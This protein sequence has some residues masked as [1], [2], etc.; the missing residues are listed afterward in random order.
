MPIA[1]RNVLFF[2]EGATLAHVGRPFVLAET[3]D[4][5]EFNVV[6]ARPRSFSWLTAPATFAVLDL[7][8]QDSATFARRLDWGQPLYDYPTLKGYV[9]QDLELIAAVKPDVIVGDFRLSLAVSARKAKVPYITV[10]DAYWSPEYPLNPPLPVLG[11]TRF[12]P[13]RVADHA[14]RLVAPLA[15]RLHTIPME[16]LRRHFGLRPIG[17]DIRQCYT[18][19][20]YRL[21]ANIPAL[22]P[23]I[24]RS[25]HGEFIGPIAW[26]PPPSGEVEQFAGKQQIVYVT[27]GSS[28]D[29]RVLNVLLPLLEQ[30][31]HKAL[32]A[33]AGKPVQKKL[34][35]ASSKI[36]DYV[37]GAT[38]CKY[39]KLVV[40]NGGSPTTNQA[41]NEGVPV[42]G[43]ARNM[44]QF[45]NMQAIA[46]YGAGIKTRSDRASRTVLGESLRELL[47][48]ERYTRRAR[49]LTNNADWDT[50]DSILR[51]ILNRP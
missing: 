17:H 11:F 42:L 13:L 51:R 12:T 30:S 49:A 34:K 10:C 28:G 2:A 4:P 15:L 29:Q 33:T 31:G 7:D 41:L 18:D 27:M 5:E 6:F 9:A 35:L 38:A 22:F 47:S 50:I 44:D 25:A 23:E 45:L 39:A 3:L 26:S 36:V 1:K 8:C 32:V 19:A 16:K 48:D 43:I 40:C 24:R 14:F 46:S 21:Y 20:D 37:S